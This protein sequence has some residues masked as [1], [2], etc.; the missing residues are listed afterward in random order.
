MLAA[1]LCEGHGNAFPSTKSLLTLHKEL[2]F[3]L[4]F[5]FTRNPESNAIELLSHISM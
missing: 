2:N 4:W 5:A 3:E 1:A